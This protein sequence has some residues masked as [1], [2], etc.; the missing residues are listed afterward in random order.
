MRCISRHT[1]RIFFSVNAAIE[2][3]AAINLNKHVK[4]YMNPDGVMFDIEQRGR[5]YFLNSMS[6]YRNNACS[7][8]EWHKILGHCN[9]DDIRKLKNVVK[10]M[11]IKDDQELE[12]EICTQGKMCQFRSREPDERAKGSL[13]LVHCDLAGPITSIAKDGFK[14]ALSF[15]DDY[16]GIH[17]VYFLR[18]KGDT[19]EATEKFLADAT[20][21]GKIKRI[22]TD[23]GMEFL[24]QGFKSILRKNAIK[25]ETSAPYS[26]HQNRK[27]ERGW[28]TLFEMARCLLLEANLPKELWTYAVMTAVYIR[29]RCFN[30]RLGKTPYEALT[31]RQP[32][33]AN[34]HV[35]GTTCSS[36]VQNAKKLDPRSVKGI[37]WAMTKRAQH[38]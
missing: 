21:S 13:E 20:P 1:S 12:C 7:L 23:N 36:Y 9:Y 10:G 35:F 28:R 6:S 3:G 17:M 24:G 30:S 38:I 8:M 16:T 22:R 5:L 34:M 26:P 25:H 37:L 14:Y 27:V 2:E 15:V 32:N 33:L 19:V 4:Q 31:T 11:K 18:Q 29:N